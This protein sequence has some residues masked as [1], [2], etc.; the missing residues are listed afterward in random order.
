MPAPPDPET[1]ELDCLT[2][3]ACCNTQRPGTIWVIEE[4]VER[5]RAEGRDDILEHLEPGHFEQLSLCM[6]DGKCV[7]HGTGEGP[8]H[9]AIYPTRPK[10]C[11]DFAVGC[12][13]CHIA[14][15]EKG[16]E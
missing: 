16:L 9:C 13:A 12:P 14:R 2:C 6:P 3:G 5:W 11:R 10:T 1:P 8:H 4:D 7:H 15:R